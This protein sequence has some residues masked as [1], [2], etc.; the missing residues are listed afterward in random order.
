MD[1]KVSPLIQPHSLV[2][3]LPWGQTTVFSTV[4]KILF[5]RT[6]LLVITTISVL[7]GSRL[8]LRDLSQEIS[9][10][11]DVYFLNASVPLRLTLSPPLPSHVHILL[12]KHVVACPIW[13]H[14]HRGCSI[15]MGPVLT[16][17]DS[18][19]NLYFTPTIIYQYSQL[20]FSGTATPFCIDRVWSLCFSIECSISA[21]MMHY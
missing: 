6:L 21:P 12:V 17:V 5:D 4:K 2:F 15:G 8:N 7:S 19:W 16:L 11:R 1:I 3:R 13:E 18:A 20:Y 9:S 14:Q 10:C